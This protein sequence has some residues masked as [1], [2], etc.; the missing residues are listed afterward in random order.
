VSG[1]SAARIGQSTVIGQSEA[2]AGAATRAARSTTRGLP[3]IERMLITN[4]ILQH[5]EISCNP[6]MV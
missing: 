1:T 6:Y 2:I 5:V 3:T 4:E